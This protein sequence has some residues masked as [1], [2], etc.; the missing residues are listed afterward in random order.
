[1]W[2]LSFEQT[3]KDSGITGVPEFPSSSAGIIQI[4]SWEC[5]SGRFTDHL[6]LETSNMIAEKFMPADHKRVLRLRL[7]LFKAEITFI[8]RA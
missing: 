1:M 2:M 3:K 4:R 8:P 7:P 6:L 5:T